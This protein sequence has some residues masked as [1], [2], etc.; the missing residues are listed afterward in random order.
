[1]TPDKTHII[2]NWL[3]ETATAIEALITWRSY[4][5]AWRLFPSPID[6]DLFMG[7]VDDLARAGLTDWFDANECGIDEL[8]AA[9]T[10]GEQC[11]EK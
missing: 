10:G 11:R 8:R 5:A 1:M 3:A 6:D 9:V 2:D 4:L 7:V